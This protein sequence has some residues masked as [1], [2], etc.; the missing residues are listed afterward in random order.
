V[1]YIVGFTVGI[2]SIKCFDNVWS[3]LNASL[4]EIID[5]LLYKV[6]PKL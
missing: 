5:M 1:L 3:F 6:L 2:E 4:F